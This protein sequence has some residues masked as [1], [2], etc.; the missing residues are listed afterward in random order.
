[1]E[2]LVRPYVPGDFELLFRL[3]RECY[4]PGI[5]YTRRLLRWFLAQPGAFCLIAEAGADI[6]GFIIADAQGE[7]GHIVTLDVATAHRRCGVGSRLVIEAER[8]LSARGVTQVEIETATEDPV[9]VAF[10]ESRGY[11][12]G[13][14]IPKYYLDRHDAYWMVK[15]LRQSDDR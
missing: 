1:V 9:A 8:R 3:D 2:I 14:I 10:W 11:R 4:P 13:G 15:A 6:A 12:T 5:A 7:D